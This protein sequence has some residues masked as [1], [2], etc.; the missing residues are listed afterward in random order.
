MVV[1]GMQSALLGVVLLVPAPSA[2]PFEVGETLAYEARVG[3]I[4]A[5]AASMSVARMDRD[6]GDEVFVLTAAGAS[7]S[8]ILSGSYTMSSWVGADRFTSRRF[9]RR[10]SFRGRVTSE[11][12]RIVGDSLRYRPEGGGQDFV[13]PAEPLDELALLYRL[14]SLP[15]EAGGS[16]E[17]RGY[18]KAGWNPV[19]VR[20]VGRQMVELGDGSNVRTVALQV[21]AAGAMSEVWLTD[22]P[23]R[24]PAQLRVPLPVG[25]VTLVLTG[26]PQA[27]RD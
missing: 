5:G 3:A 12:F 2:Y 9:Q 7:T 11:S 21:S 16:Y 17:L 10:S 13:T 25:R 24:L 14:R 27:R 19:R 15:L 4:P 22:D 23:R 6:R 1:K 26:V 8:P 18:F 20:V